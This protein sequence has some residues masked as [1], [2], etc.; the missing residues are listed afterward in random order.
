MNRPPKISVIVPVYNVEEYIQD[1]V[2]SILNQTFSDFELLLID[3]GSSDSSGKLIDEFSDID[4]RVRSIHKENQGVSATRNLGIDLAKGEFICF[5]DSDDWIDKNYFEKLFENSSSTDLIILTAVAYD[6]PNKT[7]YK[8][9][10]YKKE[11]FSNEAIPQLLIENNFFTTG[12]GGC[13]SKLFRKNII[14]EN[15]I[16]FQINNAAYEDTLFTF[17]YISKCK[18]VY[19]ARGSH[20][21]YIH[22]H[23][24]SLSKKK[25]PYKNY[26]DS[27][28]KALTLLI[29]IQNKYQIENVSTFM[30]KGITK[31][32]G[33]LNYSVFSLYPTFDQFLKQ[34][35]IN[36]LHV[37]YT[38]NVKYKNLYKTKNIKQ[39]IVHYIILFPVKHISDFLLILLF[40][41]SQITK[42]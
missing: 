40:K 32:I 24:I 30:I 11:F 23:D 7:I 5:I 35:R 10:L 13:W 14:I 3:D 18:K 34:E 9:P 33:V 16:R 12:D 31:F 42:R 22:R 41:L 25:H 8:T 28:T 4:I 1:C 27:G 19:I 38:K 6:Y 36:L 39:K 15:D 20:Y 17:E 37:L 26:L 2:H 29:E 21:H